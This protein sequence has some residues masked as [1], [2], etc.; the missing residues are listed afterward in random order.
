MAI[1]PLYTIDE[2]TTEITAFKAALRSLAAGKSYTISNGGSSQSYT[3][4]D[5]DTVRN[6]LTWLQQQRAGL[7]SAGRTQALVARPQ[8]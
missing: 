6:H 8:R 3:A 1:T 4:N 2:L 7:E 5:I